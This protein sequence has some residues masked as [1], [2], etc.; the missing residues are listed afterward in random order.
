MTNVEMMVIAEFK[1]TARTRSTSWRSS[2]PIRNMR[3]APSNAGTASCSPPGRQS[4]ST[5]VNRKVAS[6]SI[7]VSTP[8]T[9]PAEAPPP[10]QE[11]RRSLVR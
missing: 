2:S 8:V 5:T 6:A 10:Q 11:G 9:P 3:T 4:T 1:T 7:H